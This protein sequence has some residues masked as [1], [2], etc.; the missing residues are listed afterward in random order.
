MG[1][2]VQNNGCAEFDTRMECVFV[3]A[4]IQSL[5]PSRT[6]KK[7][8]WDV[9][10]NLQR[11]C[12]WTLLWSSQTYCYYNHYIMIIIYHHRL[13]CVWMG[14]LT[15]R[16]PHRYTMQLLFALLKAN[17]HTHNYFQYLLICQLVS[18]ICWGWLIISLVL[19]KTSPKSKTQFLTIYW[20]SDRPAE[21][22]CPFNLLIL[23][24]KQWLLGLC[25]HAN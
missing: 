13:K 19:S 24:Q 16:W 18:K 4:L 11:T 7:D 2:T 23:Y 10:L 25:L 14:S 20:I 3:H 5:K 17:V 8:M 1:F 15:R 6:Y 22:T 12:K 21:I 9:N